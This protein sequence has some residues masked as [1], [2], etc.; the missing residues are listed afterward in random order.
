LNHKPFLS[1][2]IR[3]CKRP[4]ALKRCLDSLVK[5]DDQDFEITILRDEIGRGVA[6]ANGMMAERDWS[7]LNGR[8]V[9]LLDDDNEMGSGAIGSIKK[10][11]LDCDMLI[12]RINRLGTKC[13]RNIRLRLWPEEDYWMK[14]PQFRHIDIGCVVLRF[15]LFVKA[16]KH[17]THRY[18]GDFDFISEAYF[19]AENVNWLN[20]PIM[21]YSIVSGGATEYD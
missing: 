17:F 1:I 21:N 14:Q 11:M 2:V 19:L 7:G 3:T 8:Y 13:Q 16:V 6:W 20:I 18:E 4:K 12:C 9:Y 10:A 15:D 5:Q